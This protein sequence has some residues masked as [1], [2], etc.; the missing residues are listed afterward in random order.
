MPPAKIDPSVL[1]QLIEVERVTQA[2]AAKQ[3]GCSKSCVERTIAR[4]G[5]QTQ[6][7]G[8]RSGAGHTNWKGGRVKVG[9]YWY[10]W[11]ETH[12]FRTRHNYMLEHRLV[13]ESMLQRYLLPHE[14]VHHKNGDPEDNRP[15]NLVV[16][17]SN[18][19]HLRHELTGKIPK[20]TPEGWARMQVGCRKTRTRRIAL[21][22]NADALPPTSGHPPSTV[23]RTG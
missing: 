15:D 3:L 21:I 16:F 20:W 13:A 22:A 9:R 23:E 8:P 17:S 4:L 14:V 19:E 5:I 1:R 7:T 12:P 2:V 11:T 10:R 6:R 18:A